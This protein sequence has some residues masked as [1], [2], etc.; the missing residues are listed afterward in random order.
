MASNHA[1]SDAPHGPKEPRRA[2]AEGQ[3]QQLSGPA[4][5]LL[6]TE[7]PAALRALAQACELEGGPWGHDLLADP[8][9]SGARSRGKAT[10]SRSMVPW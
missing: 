5:E 10:M 6:T 9:A 1:P 2:V 7:A 4:L 3:P 8:A